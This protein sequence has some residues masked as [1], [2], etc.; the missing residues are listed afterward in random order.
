MLNIIYWDYGGIFSSSASKGLFI[1]SLE[2]CARGSNSETNCKQPNPTP[3]AASMIS[4]SGGQFKI[5]YIY[6]KL[7]IIIIIIIMMMLFLK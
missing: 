3:P 6:Y 4:E 5:L 1:S 7:S 2:F